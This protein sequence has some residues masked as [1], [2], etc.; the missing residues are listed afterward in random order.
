MVGEITIKTNFK[1]EGLTKRYG[2]ITL[3]SLDIPILWK[4]EII[5]VDVKLPD[6]MF[7]AEDKVLLPISPSGAKKGIDGR[8]ITVSWIFRNKRVGDLIPIR[9]YYEPLTPKPIENFIYRWLGVFV[10]VF[11]VSIFFVYRSISKKSELV[12]S[13]L[14]EAERIVIDIIKKEGGKKVDQRKIVARS[15]FSKAKVSR[16]IK[17]LGDRGV[18]S[19]ER[20]GRKNRV[21]LKKI[22]SEG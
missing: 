16:I 2:N 21:S 9:I 13:V 5:R 17:S 18:I 4:T 19:V 1:A 20:V 22:I 11:V 15:G 10:L 14:N 7:L 8:R 12:L 3:F 6:G